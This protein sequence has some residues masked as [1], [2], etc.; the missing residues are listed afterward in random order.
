M[1]KFIDRHKM[2]PLTV[3]QLKKA[4]SA[5]R[6]KFGVTHHDILYNKKEDK[7]YCIL[8]APSKVAVAKHHREAGLNCEWIEE[9]ESTRS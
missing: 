1:P 3:G 8:N 9:I 5:P 2:G 6:D 7:V 4:Q